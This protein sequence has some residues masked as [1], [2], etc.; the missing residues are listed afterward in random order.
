MG[1]GARGGSSDGGG[2][3]GGD[4]RGGRSVGGGGGGDAG[5]AGNG[6]L[7]TIVPSDE[8]SSRDISLE[9]GEDGTACSSICPPNTL[10]ISVPFVKS[11]SSFSRGMFS[12]RCLSTFSGSAHQLRDPGGVGQT[13]SSDPPGRI[14]PF[15]HP[16]IPRIVTPATPSLGLFLFLAS[17]FLIDVEHSMEEF[18]GNISRSE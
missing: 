8:A 12:N 18:F 4:G 5:S 11:S 16:L 17:R 6:D 15:H 10:S 1:G 7:G 13:S 2:G 9:V 14:T 3:G